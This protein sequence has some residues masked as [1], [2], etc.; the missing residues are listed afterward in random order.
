MQGGQSVKG[1]DSDRNIGVDKL[2]VGG[3]VDP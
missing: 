2:S 3:E 1:G